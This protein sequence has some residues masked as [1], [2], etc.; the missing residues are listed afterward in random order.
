MIAMGSAAFAKDSDKISLENL[1]CA[2]Q[3]FLI[4]SYENRNILVTLLPNLGVNV[5]ITDI[6]Q[7]DFI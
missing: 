6:I 4:D 5:K 7:A 1:F 2:T 3:S